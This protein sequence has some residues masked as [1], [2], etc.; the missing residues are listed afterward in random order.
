MPDFAQVYRFIGSVF[1]PSSSGHLQ[2]LKQ[3]DPINLETVWLPKT[4]LLFPFH[5]SMNVEDGGC[6]N[7]AYLSVFSF[8]RSAALK[9]DELQ[10]IWLDLP[11]L[12][13]YM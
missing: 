12:D 9:T 1:D 13:S 3:M 11:I 8:C 7:E 5:V 4:I 6:E 2:R 10:V